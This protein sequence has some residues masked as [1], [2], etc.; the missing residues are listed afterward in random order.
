[1][2]VKPLVRSGDVRPGSHRRSGRTGFVFIRPKGQ[3]AVNPPSALARDHEGPPVGYRAELRRQASASA[4]PPSPPPEP[5]CLPRA[6]RSRRRGD[7]DP[8]GSRADATAWA[9]TVP[10]GPG[11]CRPGARPETAP[12]PRHR[13]SEVP[14]I[15]R[16]PRQRSETPRIDDVRDPARAPV[17]W[18]PGRRSAGTPARR[19]MPPRRG[20]MATMLA[21]SSTGRQ[22]H[23]P[24]T[25]GA[26]DDRHAVGGAPV[27]VDLPL[28]SSRPAHHHDALPGREHPQRRDGVGEKVQSGQGLGVD[29]GY[30]DQATRR[31]V[32]GVI[33]RTSGGRLQTT[34]GIPSLAN[35]ARS[36]FTIC[37]WNGASWAASAA[38]VPPAA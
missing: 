5:R 15:L 29:G 10:A 24:T 14:A 33:L 26:D 19:E 21:V 1:M 2:R 32:I 13:R 7:P 31:S 8:A 37:P 22:H 12:G 18:P 4:P 38:P 20:A 36:G 11:P 17:P 9:G 30:A 34:S 25:G 23:R 3:V 28:G 35:Y 6:T 27:E 16:S